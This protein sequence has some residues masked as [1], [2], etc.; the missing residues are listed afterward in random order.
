MIVVLTDFGNSEY[1]GAM[2]GVIHST[3]QDI[4]IVDLC[5]DLNSIKEGAWVLLK[6]YGLFPKGSIFLCVVDPGVGSERKP[7]VV[8]S[9]NYYFVGPDNGLMYPALAD[10][11]IMRVSEII[12]EKNISE[13]FHGRDVFAPAAARLEM[14][15]AV[16]LGNE[17]SMQK[18]EF[19]QSGRTGEV[20]RIDKFGNIITNLPSEGKKI[21]ELSAG[22]LTKILPFFRTYSEA[23]RNTPFLVKGSSDTL[24]ISYYGK[25]AASELKIPL[26]ERITIR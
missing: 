26:G 14:G 1:L 3:H 17:L 5:H 12:I 2:K 6:N 23:P 7:L 8:Q 16:K 10:D 4:K 9:E 20:V 13:T 22:S 11:R 25:S 18:L 24:E 19:Y 21:Y 15:A